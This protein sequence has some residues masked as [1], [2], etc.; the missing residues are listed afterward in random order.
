M[1]RPFLPPSAGWAVFKVREASDRGAPRPHREAPRRDPY[2]ERHPLLNL[3]DAYLD[4]AHIVDESVDLPV[5]VAE[6]TGSPPRR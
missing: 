6:V 5:D 1:R 4:V 3:G 2:E